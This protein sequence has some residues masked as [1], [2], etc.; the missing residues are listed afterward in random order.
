MK[1]HH[2][3]LGACTTAGGTVTSATS[4]MSVDGIRIA[5]EGDE[6]HCDTCAS[7]GLIR[8]IGPR[9]PEQ[10]NG[11][12]VALEN[13]LC[14]CQCVPHPRLLPGQTRKF[15]FVDAASTDWVAQSNR[16]EGKHGAAFD[17][18]FLLLDSMTGA[19][20]ARQPYRLRHGGTV[21]EGM[22]DEDGYTSPIPTGS[23][24]DIVEWTILG[25]HRHG[26]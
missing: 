13:D 23:R 9:M 20:L 11:K 5:L 25:E 14:I 12:Q 21:V 15:Q 2:I 19:P 3:T 26:E 24:S 16:T 8:C 17:Q 18:R 1:R 6:I 7:T 10:Y 4:P 22:T